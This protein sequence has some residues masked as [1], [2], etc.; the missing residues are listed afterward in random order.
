MYYLFDL[1]GTIIDSNGIWVDVDTA[2]LA[3][4]GMPYTQ[5][6]ADGVAHTIFPLAAKF[7]KEYCHIEDSEESIMA[8]WMDLAGDRYSETVELKP[9]TADYLRKCHESGIRMSLLS[10]CVPAHGKA[11]LARHG[12]TEYFE[13]LIFAHDIG[14]EKSDPRI[15]EEAAKICGVSPEDCVLF[16]D[17]SRSCLCA[18]KAGLKTVGV[19]DKMFCREEEQ[20]RAECDRYIMSFEELLNE[21]LSF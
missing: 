16:D 20:L 13:H 4:R 1:D 15:F 6:Y 3:R 18:K 5:E 10:S 11:A 2:F 14:I 21:P 9:F 12:L 17:S 8:E 7:T 19:Y